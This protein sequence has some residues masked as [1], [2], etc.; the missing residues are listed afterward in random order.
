MQEKVRERLAKEGAEQRQVA[1][2]RSSKYPRFANKPRRETESTAFIAFE[3]Y[4]QPP[5]S[6]HELTQKRS[7]YI[8]C[9]QD[10]RQHV[11]GA[12]FRH[13]VD[14]QLAP[15]QC[16]SIHHS[17]PRSAHRIHKCLLYS[18]GASASQCLW[19]LALCRISQQL[20]HLRQGPEAALRC[21]QQSAAQP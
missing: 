5:S 1:Q 15:R 19:Q 2:A 7:S 11:Q 17:S 21:A 8:T 6:G 4:D 18:S 12:R 9:L 13:T 14:A 16:P 20:P 3:I 10:S